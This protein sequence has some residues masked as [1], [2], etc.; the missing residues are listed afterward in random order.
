VGLDHPCNYAL[1]GLYGEN[2]YVYFIR[3]GKAGPIKIGIAS[4]VERRIADMQTGNAY[5]LESILTIPCKSR[6]HAQSVENSLHA[7]FRKQ[8]IRGEW[9][10]GNINIKKVEKRLIELMAIE[11]GL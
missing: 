9:F 2:M 6:I 5:I 1:S 10:T 4:D 3:A 8:R 7:F 11:S